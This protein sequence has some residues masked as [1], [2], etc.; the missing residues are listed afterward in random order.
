MTFLG[1]TVE[2]WAMQS[3]PEH[4]HFAPW[5]RGRYDNVERRTRATDADYQRGR[6]YW[7]ERAMRKLRGQA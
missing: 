4:L 7:Q 2:V 3:P 1:L 5:R 6:R